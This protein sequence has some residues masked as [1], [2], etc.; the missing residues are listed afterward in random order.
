[1]SVN[2]RSPRTVAAALALLLATIFGATWITGSAQA[3][4]PRPII[5]ASTHAV[6]KAGGSGWQGGFTYAPAVGQGGVFFHYGCPAGYIARSGGFSGN[7]AGQT[8][9]QLVGMGP[10]LDLGAANYTEWFWTLKW[11]GGAAAGSQITFDVH[12]TLAPA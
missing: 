12:C 9:I 4:T 2:F 1:M 6:A 7:A 5:S 11:S 8:G 10:R 3:N